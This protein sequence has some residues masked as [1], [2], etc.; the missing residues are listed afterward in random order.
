MHVNELI[1]EGI[2]CHVANMQNQQCSD[3]LYTRHVTDKPLQSKINC[4]LLT[5]PPVEYLNFIDKND[6]C[7][8]CDNISL[9]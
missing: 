4:F 3:K 1:Y 8:E 2:D 7:A 6:A 5:L 9:S